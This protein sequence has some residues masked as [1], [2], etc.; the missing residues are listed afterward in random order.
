MK[1]WQNFYDRTNNIP[2]RKNIIYFISNYKISGNA[3]DLG[4]GAGNDTI[5]LIQNDFNVLAID[6]SDVEERIRSKLSD[7]EQNKLKFEIQTFE[8]LKLPECNL[9]IS[10]NSLSFCKRSCF[11]DMWKEICSSIK[12]NGYFVG[13]FF[14]VNDEWNTENTD[15]TFLTKEE[16]IELFN[17]FEILKIQ[18]IEKNRPTAEGQMKHWHSIEIIAQKRNKKE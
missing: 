14:G 4:C 8:S 9:I 5:Y 18:D 17:D 11:Y 3:I 10:N 15:K 6:S 16:A 7:S 2:P 12:N 13:N 1:D